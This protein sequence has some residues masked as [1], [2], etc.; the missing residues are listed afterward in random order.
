MTKAAYFNIF[1]KTERPQHLDELLMIDRGTS[2]IPVNQFPEKYTS[3]PVMTRT[4]FEETDSIFV[5]KPEDEFYNIHK[6]AYRD[7]TIG[8]HCWVDIDVEVFCDS[9][10]N[11]ELLIVAAMEHK[12][13]TAIPHKASPKTHSNQVSG[14]R[15]TCPISHLQSETPKICWRPI[16]GNGKTGKYSS[17]KSR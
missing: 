15:F 16:C 7:L 2:G 17:E 14:T 9:I 12:V 4:F 3:I 8:E 5:M 6:T 1:L 11:D 10:L 13:T